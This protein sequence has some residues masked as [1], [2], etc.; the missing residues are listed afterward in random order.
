M[1]RS[2]TVE[3]T[4]TVDHTKPRNTRSR[5]RSAYDDVVD[6]FRELA[7]LDEGSAPYRRQRD[8]IIERCLPLA[9]H[10]ARRFRGRGEAHEDLVQVARVGLLN[11]VNRF[12][13]DSANDFLAFA[14]PTMMGEVRRYFRDHGWSLKVPRRLKELNVR[15]NSARSELTH[16]LNRAPTP[17]ELAEFLGMERDEIVE[18]LVA[19]NAY[20]TRSTE[21]ETMRTGDGD[22]LT[23][24]DTIGGPDEGIQRVID[25]QTVQPLLAKLPARDRLVLQLRFFDNLTQSQIAERIGVSQ[26]HVSRLLARAL[27]TLRE[28]IG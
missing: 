12:D 28:Q 18:G 26:M 11:A 22:G 13:V 9:D 16:Q 24:L 21:Q 27:A 15:L 20:S 25:I 2:K 7:L 8:A 6:M 14:V 4:N 10:I 1:E 19:A 5:S 23:L 17:S 3:H